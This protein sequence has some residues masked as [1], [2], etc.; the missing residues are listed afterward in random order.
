MTQLN[1][2][3][4]AWTLQQQFNQSPVLFVSPEGFSECLMQHSGIVAITDGWKDG[5][6]ATVLRGGINAQS[7]LEL[8]NRSGVSALKMYHIE[9]RVPALEEMFLSSV[10][11]PAQSLFDSVDVAWRRDPSLFDLIKQIGG[12]YSML[13]LGAPLAA[14]EIMPLYH[15]I[16]E[17]F[18]GS[19]TIVRGPMTE[20]VLDESDEINRWVRERTFDASD[21]SLPAILRTY[22]QKLGKKIA[23]LLP[24]LNEEKT[25]GNV[26]KTALEVQESGLI[27]EVIL[28]D[29]ASTDNTVAIAKSFGI[30]FYLHREIRPEFGSFHGKGE[31]MFKSMYVTD[32]DIVAWVDTDIES[33]AP[34]FFYG[35]LGPLLT[36]PTLKFSKGYFSRPVRIETSGVELGG[37][38]V[39]EILARP[40]LNAFNPELSG[41][42]QP[43]AGTVAIYRDLVM[44]MRI[45][46]NYGVEAAMLL[47]AV[48]DAGLWATCQVN[49]GE[50]IHRSKD[51]AG[52]SEMSF[53]IIQVLASMAPT[54][55]AMPANDLLRRVHSAHGQFLISSKR[56]RTIWRNFTA[57][58]GEGNA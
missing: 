4:P 17:V 7:T 52:L 49:L 19:L 43:L 29:S 22:K 41:Y 28:I 42:I 47:Q 35:L 13:F 25:V 31:A 40:W 23:V 33:I 57:E 48:Q 24:S 6:I 39:T 10:V 11:M 51:V 18:A 55:F 14:S 36:D 50:V 21:F 38:R 32:A 9:E 20:L 27:D 5:P 44:P 37:G 3:T 34:R 46:V 56:F 8:L 16:K 1:I 30:P 26:I 2:T 15:K 45:P 58:G 12:N 54:N 53:Q